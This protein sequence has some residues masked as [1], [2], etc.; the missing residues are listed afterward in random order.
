M[1]NE[2]DVRLYVYAVIGYASYGSKP[3]YDS[4]PEPLWTGTR[5]VIMCRCRWVQWS[6]LIAVF[7]MTTTGWVAS[8]SHIIGYGVLQVSLERLFRL[9]LPEDPCLRV[10]IIILSLSPP[11]TSCWAHGRP[12]WNQALS[13]LIRCSYLSGWIFS[14]TNRDS[15]NAKGKWFPRKHS[16]APLV[17][18]RD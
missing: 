8:R 17:W 1:A 13:Y 15:E 2:S 18:H 12:N 9:L 16:S 5:N 4:P 11:V 7:C 6:N 10:P 14:W 3:T